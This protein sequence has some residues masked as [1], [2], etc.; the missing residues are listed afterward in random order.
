M[1]SMFLRTNVLNSLR[2]NVLNSRRVISIQ[3]QCSLQEQCSQFKNNVLN[4][5]TMFSIQEQYS[6]FKNNVIYLGISFLDVFSVLVYTYQ[7]LE[8]FTYQKVV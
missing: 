5:R 7:K 4:S 2:T 6:Q 3:E 8:V 1:F